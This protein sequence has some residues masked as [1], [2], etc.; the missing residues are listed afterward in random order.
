MIRT[1][2]R[3]AVLRV[4]AAVALLGMSV[5]TPLAVRAAGLAYLPGAERSDVIAGRPDLSA[6]TWRL[7]GGLLVADR[8]GEGS[9]HRYGQAM[10]PVF[11]DSEFFLIQPRHAP[12]EGKQA[13][14]HF[15]HIH[16][17][18]GE[19]LVIE[20]PRASLDA[21]HAVAADLTRIPLTP[22]PVGWDRVPDAPAMAPA[23]QPSE[24]VVQEFVDGLVASNMYDVIKEISGDQTFW[25]DGANRSV[26]TRYY[27]T[28]DNN[29]VADYLA[30]KL[31]NWGY[32]VEL[33]T[34]M[35]SGNICRNVV[36]TKIGTTTPSEYVIVGGHYDS[37]SPSPTTAAPG[38]E[39]NGS[40]TALVMGI[41]EAAAGRD[42]EKSVQFVLFDAEE[43]GLIGSSHFVDEAVAES[44]NI[45]AAIVVDMVC[46]WD[47]HYGMRIEGQTYW[48]WLMTIT[49]D[50]VAAFTDISSGKDYNSWGSDHV[51]FQQAGIAAFLAI[52][53][54]WSTYPAY[55]RTTDTWSL[56]AGSAEVGY[57][58]MKACA[59]TLA[60]VALLEPL[61]AVDGAPPAPHASLVA[62][63]NPFNPRVAVTFSLAE[64]ATG[65]LSVFDLAGRR[66]AVLA[67]GDLAAGE[68]TV[69]W[70]GTGAAGETLPSG[71]Y[72]CRLKAGRQEARV[73]LNLVR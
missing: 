37:I 56:I 10:R 48:E 34:F 42:F 29:L 17:S 50:N 65:D 1:G 31:A 32:A 45:I 46:W 41:A 15:G 54:D 7:P 18:D 53:W 57:Q 5:A 28:A 33:E 73:K 13:V 62:R 60:D 66:V 51:P 9:S 11:D 12:T 22:P 2:S 24:S 63:P 14:A 52:D 8:L 43:V 69:T 44:R 6:L 35:Y 49:E 39:D 4:L 30:D 38:A 21:F 47:T 61:S 59:A 25:Y 58:I 27:N 64:A 23:K 71:T 20:V 19:S 68:R 26:S 72:L 55:H 40:G 3:P 36:A 67:S 70:D 16:L